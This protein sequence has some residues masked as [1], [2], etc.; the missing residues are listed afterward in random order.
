MKTTEKENEIRRLLEGWYSATLSA[1]E[2]HRLQE[3]L[4]K[5]DDL[6]ADLE[7]ERDLLSALQ[8]AGRDETELPEEYSSRINLALEREMSATR[9]QSK[10]MRRR[11][12]GAA[13]AVALFA[14]G[15]G[16][17]FQ[18]GTDRSSHEQLAVVNKPRIE[19]PKAEKIVIA[20]EPDAAEKMAGTDVRAHAKKHRPE[21]RQ[22]DQ[23]EADE[24]ETLTGNYHVVTD[25]REAEAMLAAIFGRLE[26]QV[27]IEN[28]RVA[29]IKGE[30]ET[31]MNKLENPIMVSNIQ[32]DYHEES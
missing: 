26:S 29:E 24:E 23:I 11:L 21:R 8:A 25:E 20:E 7:A 15:A 6:P 1:E 2:E 13:A 16:I 30:Y 27:S 14:V 12:W 28:E 18:T 5:A 17:A 31:E 19:T 32:T 10:V 3:L 9:M 4:L 22:H